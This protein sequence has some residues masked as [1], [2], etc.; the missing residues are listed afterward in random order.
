MG[1]VDLVLRAMYGD[2]SGV[3]K[4]VLG[5]NLAAMMDSQLYHSR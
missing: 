5:A 2:P 3:W 1:M 4:R